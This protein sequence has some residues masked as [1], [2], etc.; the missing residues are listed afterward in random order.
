[1]LN[2]NR[3]IPVRHF[4]TLSSTLDTAK[5]W[6][7][8]GKEVI[9]VA[10]KQTRGRGREGRSFSSQAGGLYLGW[11]HF[12]QD[13][14]AKD[15][16]WLVA[17]GAVAVC[18]TLE[19]YGLSPTIKWPNDV[20]LGGKKICGILTENTLSGDRIQSTVVGI[21]L[22]VNNRLED[23]L[24]PIATSLKEALNKKVSLREVERRLFSYLAT[25]FNRV[26]YYSRLGSLGEV[27]ILENGTCYSAI[28][29]GIDEQGL[30]IVSVSGER[31]KKSAAE[32]SLRKVEKR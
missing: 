4:F 14:K 18:K 10:K 17:R 26:D 5:K 16:F 7:N 1:M 8:K 30:L 32:I 31:Q 12:P 3:K 27:E 2:K 29:E 13:M 25:S 9:I 19:D 24:L 22:N 21:G 28:A 15:G 11:L 6:K 23:S 20:L